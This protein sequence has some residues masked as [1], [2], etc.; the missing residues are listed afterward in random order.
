M[1]R[2]TKEQIHIFWRLHCLNHVSDVTEMLQA[3]LSRGRYKKVCRVLFSLC[4]Q[5]RQGLYGLPR[6][7]C[8]KRTYCIKCF[9]YQTNLLFQPTI[10]WLREHLTKHLSIGNLKGVSFLSICCLSGRYWGGIS[11]GALYNIVTDEI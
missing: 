8:N 1:A 10:Y 6:L 7:T 3:K 9:L 11:L 2:N 5:N 4:P